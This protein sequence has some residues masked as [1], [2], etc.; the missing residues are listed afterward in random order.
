MS[1]SYPA[2]NQVDVYIN[3]PLVYTF[4]QDVDEASLYS[5]A[6]LLY[7]NKDEYVVDGTLSYDKETFTITFLPETA[8][9]PNTSYTWTFAGGDDPDVYPLKFSDGSKLEESIFVDFQTGE[10]VFTKKEQESEIE[11]LG[12]IEDGQTILERRADEFKVVATSPE[13]LSSLVDVDLKKIVIEFSSALKEGI[14]PKDFV[15][16]SEQP[17]L[18]SNYLFNSGSF[19]SVVSKEPGAKSTSSDKFGIPEYTVTLGT[20]RKELTLELS[21]DLNFNA[22]AIIIVE[23]NGNLKDS[24]DELL[25]KGQNE[26]FY[27]LTEVYPMLS[28]PQSVLLA[29]SE[30]EGEV[31]EEL[32]YK[33]ILKNSFEIWELAGR[34]FPL[35]S[36][37]SAAISYVECATVIDLIDNKNISKQINK[38]KTMKLADLTISF[39]FP[40]NPESDIVSVRGSSAECKRESKMEVITLAGKGDFKIGE[41]GKNASLVNGVYRN[42]VKFSSTRRNSTNTGS[43]F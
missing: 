23:I 31:S 3:K 40:R 11:E 1:K 5:G 18:R 6:I 36:P 42:R 12:I 10:D 19:N 38:G 14:D 32:V 22:N 35:T 17:L 21:D 20:D 29:L 39:D 8:L 34:T 26:R 13:H 28:N 30:I 4:G 15:T 16:I 9:I 24:K 7:D 25:N 33:Y 27:F 43:G 37:P 2:K 41:R